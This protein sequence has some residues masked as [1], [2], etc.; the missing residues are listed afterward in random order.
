MDQPPKQYKLDI[1][2]TLQEV[3]DRGYGIGNGRFEL[4]DTVEL[5][6][7]P[8]PELLAIM[9]NVHAVFTNLPKKGKL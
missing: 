6:T 8:F 2:M 7:L 4:A 9:S 5:G 3:D 1:R